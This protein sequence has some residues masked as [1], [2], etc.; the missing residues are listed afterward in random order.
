MHEIVIRLPIEIVTRSIF[1]TTEILHIREI[2]Q[3]NYTVIFS[4][5][6][7]ITLEYCIVNLIAMSLSKVIN[8]R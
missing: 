2:I 5:L 6:S 1:N 4:L 3:I 7:F 8:I